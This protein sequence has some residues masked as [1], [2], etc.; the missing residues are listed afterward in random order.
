[1]RPLLCEEAATASLEIARTI[2]ANGEDL[3]AVEVATPCKGVILQGLK[4][5]GL[6]RANA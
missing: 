3:D 6:A 4:E 5:G 2:V 1:V